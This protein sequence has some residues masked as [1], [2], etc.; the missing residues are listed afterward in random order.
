MLT[1]IAQQM[2]DAREAKKPRIAR[3]RPATPTQKT[4]RRPKAS[5]STWRL[6]ELEN[7]SVVIKRDVAPSDMIPKRFFNLAHLE[8]FADCLHRSLV[9]LLTGLG[10]QDICKLSAEEAR[11]LDLIDESS[12]RCEVVFRAFSRMFQ[13]QPALRE[14]ALSRKRGEHK[15]SQNVVLQTASTGTV[16]NR[17]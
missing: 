14:L 13:A 10:K 12:V 2:A 17:K 15:S 5:A 4:A 7:C 11:D 1:A 3:R 9:V 16:C 6:A 8:R